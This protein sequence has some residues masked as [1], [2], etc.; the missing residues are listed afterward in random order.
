MPFTNSN[1]Y[2]DGRKPPV[3][4]AGGEVVERLGA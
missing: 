3:F 4:P 1:D 2:L